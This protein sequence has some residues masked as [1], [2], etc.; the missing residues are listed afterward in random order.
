MPF[1]VLFGSKVILFLGEFLLYSPFSVIF[2]SID[3]SLR[4]NNVFIGIGEGFLQFGELSIDAFSLGLV[5]LNLGVLFLYFQTLDLGLNLLHRQMDFFTHRL[6]YI[7]I[8]T[9]HRTLGK[10]TQPPLIKCAW[11]CRF[12]VVGSIFWDRL[13]EKYNLLMHKGSSL[14]KKE[15]SPNEKLLKSFY[16]KQKSKS[17]YSPN[18]NRSISKEQIKHQIK[19]VVY[20]CNH[21]SER[22]IAARHNS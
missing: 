6:D 7:T 11:R 9:S 5:G 8:S 14:K 16:S 1:F 3:D 15:K 13:F 20:N 18:A 22:V 4:I 21:P 2:H 19:K 12:E 10:G 17:E